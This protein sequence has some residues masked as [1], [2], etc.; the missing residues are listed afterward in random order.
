M[1]LAKLVAII[2]LAHAVIAKYHG[3][4]VGC[5]L[6]LGKYPIGR[7]NSLPPDY[8]LVQFLCFNFA[9]RENQRHS[10]IIPNHA[11]GSLCSWAIRPMSIFAVVSATSQLVS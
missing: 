10:K 8:K 4:N 11:A 2:I 9:G 1:E 3:P 7:K 5:V 6:G